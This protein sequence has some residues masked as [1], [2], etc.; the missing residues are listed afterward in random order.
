M[1]GVPIVS[2]YFHSDAVAHLPGAI[3]GRIRVRRGHV[4]PDRTLEGG[5]ES[6]NTSG[7]DYPTA[8]WRSLPS[9][10]IRIV[11]PICQYE[12]RGVRAWRIEVGR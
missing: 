11:E 2:I 10:C 3:H 1:V 8:C 12:G 7:S 4:V 6:L 9:K 5:K